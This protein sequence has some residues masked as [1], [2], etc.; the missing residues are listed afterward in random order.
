MEKNLTKYTKDLN[1]LFI[2]FLFSSF[3]FFWD[4]SFNFLQLR[5]LIFLLIIP[6]LFKLDKI[7]IK[8][9]IKYFLVPFLIFLH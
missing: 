6:I 9:T 2:S 5:F 1:Y 3:I 4:I 7:L 8:K